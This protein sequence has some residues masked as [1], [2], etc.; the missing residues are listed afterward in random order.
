MFRLITTVKR[1]CAPDLAATWIVYS[2]VDAARAAATSLMRDERVIHVA[3]TD[4]EVPPH[5]V[6]WAG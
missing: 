6:E 3:I 2:T 5:F 1:G 4:D